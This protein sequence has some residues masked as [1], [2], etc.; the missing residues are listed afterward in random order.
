M[1]AK[2]WSSSDLPF[3][4]HPCTVCGLII[5][6]GL[7]LDQSVRGCS[8]QGPGMVKIRWY[9]L[10]VL[11]HHDR[12]KISPCAFLP[13]WGLMTSEELRHFEELPSPHN[14]FWVPCMWFVNLALRARTEGRINNDVALTAI[15]TVGVLERSAAGFKSL[16]LF[17]FWRYQIWQIF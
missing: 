2:P 13:L 3:F 1:A 17:T 6:T 15:L 10:R 9:S 16:S 14:K 4:S 5:R 8:F 11:N 7:L 12:S